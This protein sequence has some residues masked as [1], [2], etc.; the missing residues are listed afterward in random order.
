MPIR[1]EHQ[2]FKSSYS[3]GSGTECVEAAFVRDGCA[4]RDSKDPSGPRLSFRS[5]AWAD[6]MGAVRNARL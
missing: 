6:F 4:V 3:G 5:E 1:S 2:W